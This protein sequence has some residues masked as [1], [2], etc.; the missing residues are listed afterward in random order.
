M[1]VTVCW[2][3]VPRSFM[4]V[5]DVSE[6]LTAAIIKRPSI[7]ARMSVQCARR[8]SSLVLTSLRGTGIRV[9]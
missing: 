3:I 6:V 2:A 4:K 8:L 5:T 1:K 7:S 9:K